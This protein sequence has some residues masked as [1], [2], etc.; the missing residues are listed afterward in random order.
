MKSSVALQLVDI[1]RYTLKQSS[2]ELLLDTVA[3]LLLL[4]LI[5]LNQGVME[6]ITSLWNHR[7][8][9]VR[10][11]VYKSLKRNIGYIENRFNS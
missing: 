8:S 6:D 1:V 3:D 4:L 9:A 10:K 5:E 7:S 11:S 2:D